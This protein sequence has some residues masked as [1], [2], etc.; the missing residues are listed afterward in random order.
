MNDILNSTAAARDSKQQQKHSD[1]DSKKVESQR[2][3]FC[4]L[5]I[6]FGLNASKYVNEDFKEEY[7]VLGSYPDLQKHPEVAAEHKFV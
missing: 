5:F 4:S 1:S 6:I 3:S 2:K 7:E